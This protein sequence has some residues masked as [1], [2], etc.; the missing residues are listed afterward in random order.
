MKPL[1]IV[2]NI[3]PFNFLPKIGVLYDFDF[4]K[5]DSI[6]GKIIP[7]LKASGHDEK[8][9]GNKNVLLIEE[10][11]TTGL[12]GK[13]DECFYESN[14]PNSEKWNAFWYGEGLEIKNKN[15]FYDFFVNL[16]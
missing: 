7:H 3:L 1:F 11:N 8:N 5:L 9:L 15:S 12:T 16:Q 4:K 13:T 10:L 2:N 14:D 6:S